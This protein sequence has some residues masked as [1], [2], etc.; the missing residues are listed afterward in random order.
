MNAECTERQIE[1]LL[2]GLRRD[3][4]DVMAERWKGLRQRT[5]NGG[6]LSR[7]GFR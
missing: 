3:D 4:K 2:E 5:K 1:N 6:R 7:G